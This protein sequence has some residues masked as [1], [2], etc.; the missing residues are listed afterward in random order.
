MS[1]NGLLF[2]MMEMLAN[3]IVV[4]VEQLYKIY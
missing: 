2:G 3:E 4:V 1:A